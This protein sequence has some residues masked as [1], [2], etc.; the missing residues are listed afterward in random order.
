[1]DTGVHFS[2]EWNNNGIVGR[3]VSFAAA[4]EFEAVWLY[5]LG[6]TGLPL[7]F[8]GFANF[9]LPKGRDAFG[10]HAYKGILSRPQ[11]QSDF[12]KPLYNKPHLYLAVELWL[13][14]SGNGSNVSGSSETSQVVGVEVHF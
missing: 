7:D 11:F 4:P 3:T 12:G 14:I 2:K 1:M 5:P 13:H 9:V 8:R 10:N 6:F